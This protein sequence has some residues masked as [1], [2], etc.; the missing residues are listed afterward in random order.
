MHF[1]NIYLILILILKE[2]VIVENIRLVRL[3]QLTVSQNKR[4][5]DADYHAVQRRAKLVFKV[6]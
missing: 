6:V 1:R 5:D 4:K 2:N 3:Q